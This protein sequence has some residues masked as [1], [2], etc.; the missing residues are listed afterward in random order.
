MI[1]KRNS[2]AAA[3]IFPPVKKLGDPLRFLLSLCCCFY[4]SVGVTF[5]LWPSGFPAAFRTCFS[6]TPRQWSKGEFEEVLLSPP[7]SC[8]LLSICSGRKLKVREA[9]D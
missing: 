7:A 2:L 5:S 9:T 3:G 8:L 4:V 1:V 6:G